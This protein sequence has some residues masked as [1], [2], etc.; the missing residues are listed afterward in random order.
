MLLRG[1]D[2]LRTAITPLVLWE[3][4]PFTGQVYTG[5]TPLAGQEQRSNCGPGRRLARDPVVMPD[6]THHF[7]C[8]PVA[9]EPVREMPTHVGEPCP[10]GQHRPDRRG[11]C[12]P[13]PHDPR[14]SDREV[15]CRNRGWVWDGD[16]CVDPARIRA[17]GALVARNRALMNACLEAGGTWSPP[18]QPGQLGSCSTGSGDGDGNG[19]GGGDGNG[20]GGPGA[21]GPPTGGGV[22]DPLTG[23]GGSAGPTQTGDPRCS[24]GEEWI[25]MLQRCMKICPPGFLRDSHGRCNNLA[26]PATVQAELPQIGGMDEPAAQA[27]GVLGPG[28][29]AP[30]R[31]PSMADLLADPRYLTARREQERAIRGAAAAGGISGAPLLSALADSAG[32]LLTGLYA[33]ARGQ[34]LEDWRTNFARG[35]DI[36]QRAVGH[37]GRQFEPL[38]FA[39][40]VGLAAGDQRFKHWRGAQD[41]GLR[42]QQQAWQQ[43]YMPWRDQLQDRLARYGIDQGTAMQ[44]LAGMGGWNN[45]LP[46]APV[47]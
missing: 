29:V 8:V 32:G 27:A 18:S 26:N 15:V 20:G 7:P 42:Q 36:Y 34:D 41:L 35:N 21:G 19:D 11:P 38:R 10:P 47:Y 9:R 23:A 46:Q 30:W 31:P 22:V 37:W 6:G 17:G 25:D 45:P 33:Q 24:G 5:T 16:K 3:Y 2:W 14:V 44:I 12:V 39:S 4:D 13:T 28:V 1:F 40:T 43:Q